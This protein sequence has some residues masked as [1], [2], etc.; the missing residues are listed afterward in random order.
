MDGASVAWFPRSVSQSFTAVLYMD[1][2]AVILSI[3]IVALIILKFVTG[4]KDF[5][6]RS[7]DCNRLF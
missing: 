4:V 7:A 3:A 1:G 6:T 5:H 2:F